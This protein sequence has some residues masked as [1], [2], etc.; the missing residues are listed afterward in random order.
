MDSDPATTTAHFKP[1]TFHA[2]A[3]EITVAALGTISSPSD[4][5]GVWTTPGSVSGAWF[6]SATTTTS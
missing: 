2:L 5:K 4:T 1:A 6:S 3:A